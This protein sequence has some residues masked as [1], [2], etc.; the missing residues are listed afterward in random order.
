M[1]SLF[2]DLLTFGLLAPFIIRLTLG[3]FYIVWGNKHLR[4]VWGKGGR[5]MDHLVW[6]TSRFSVLAAFLAGISVFAGLY[7][8]VGALV[9]A[10]LSLFFA[11]NEPST[12]VQFLLLAAMAFSLLFSGAGFFAFDLPL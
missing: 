6:W 2:P 9:L 1:L 10:A 12:R 8:Q 3:L 7:M 11:Y 5:N 4:I